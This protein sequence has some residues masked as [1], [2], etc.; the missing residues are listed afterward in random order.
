MNAL[1]VID[2]L[3]PA[4]FSE[5]GGIDALLSKLETDVRAVKTD[6][7]TKAGRTAIAS[8]AFKVARSK[9]ALD[10]MGKEL[11]D[12]HY[13]S[14]KAIC[15]ER[16]RI[17]ARLDALRDEVRKPL[18]DYEAAEDARIAGHQG[19][20][21]SILDLAAFDSEF[22]ASGAVIRSLAELDTLP[23]RDWQE[24]AREAEVARLQTFEK[25]TALKDA[26]L[27]REAEAAEI[28]RA[29]LEQLAVAQKERDD[30]IAAEAAARA[31][32]AAEAKARLD[33]ENLE[34]D[35]LA[36]IAKTA[37]AER[38]TALAAER[39]ETARVETAARVERERIAAAAQA[40][41]DR[42]A[43]IDAERR[44]VAN[45]EAAERAETERREADAAHK[46]A[47]HTEVLDALITA[48]LTIEQGA[49]V[50]TAI[51]TQKIPYVKLEY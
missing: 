39:A 38:E 45:I 26:S 41:A 51:V 13:K 48:G 4:V 27:T 16:T 49:I 37:Q 36:A 23:A 10:A 20:L 1:V 40:E 9:T 34:R 42:L 7:A 30:A 22:P 6:V 47:V 18:D 44:R 31:T 8:L 19:A 35:R 24:F 11:G 2:T 5:P 33:R 25:L 43:A 3:T 14:W 32:L 12:G 29:R 17:E 50:I 21:Q 15:S 28:E 46:K